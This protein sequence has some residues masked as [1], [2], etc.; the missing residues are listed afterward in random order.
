MC[1]L[2]LWSRVHFF[3]QTSPLV[4]ISKGRVSTVCREVGQ[5]LWGPSEIVPTRGHPG[6]VAGGGGVPP[7]EAAGGVLGVR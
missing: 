7:A 4:P 6:G 5:T 3:S 2:N 1:G